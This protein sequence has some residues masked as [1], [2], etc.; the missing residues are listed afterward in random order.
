MVGAINIGNRMD[1]SNPRRRGGIRLPCV[2]SAASRHE[3]KKP[4]AM[5]IWTTYVL[6]LLVE[7]AVCKTYLCPN[8][9]ALRMRYARV[10]HMPF[11]EAKFGVCKAYLCPNSDALRTRYAHAIFGGQIRRV[12]GVCV[13]K[14]ASLATALASRAAGKLGAYY[15]I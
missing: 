15:M 7:F 11:L 12:Q 6:F 9:D 5:A 2:R 8:S 13:S 14:L 1:I 10:T 4:P 3:A